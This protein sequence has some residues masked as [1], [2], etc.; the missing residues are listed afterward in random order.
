M[1]ICRRGDVSNR[2]K[3]AED[4]LVSRQ[5]TSDDANNVRVAAERSKRVPDGFRE[6]EVRPI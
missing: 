1:P 6:I 2:I 3:I 4:F 5:L